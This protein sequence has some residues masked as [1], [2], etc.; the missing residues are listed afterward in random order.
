LYIRGRPWTITVDDY[1]PLY[2][3]NLIFENKS[4]QNGNY[5]AVI[6]EKVFAK[7]TGNYE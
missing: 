2:N 1:I 3:G 6:L 7:I 5:W 4:G